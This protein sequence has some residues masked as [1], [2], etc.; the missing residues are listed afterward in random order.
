M[1]IRLGLS[2]IVGVSMTLALFYLMQFLIS[3]G[4]SVLSEEKGRSDC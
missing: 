4:K 3:G 2:T 1:I